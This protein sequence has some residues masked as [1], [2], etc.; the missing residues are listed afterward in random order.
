MGVMT[1]SYALKLEEQET[2]INLSRTQEE[3]I[4]YTSDRTKYTKLDRL[5]QELPETYRCIWEDS[6]IAA[7]GKPIGK[8]Y[9]CPSRLIRFGRPIA[10]TEEQIEAMRIRG[11]A[12]AQRFI[13]NVSRRRG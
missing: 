8:K 6:V 10:R 12:N 4:I 9:S 3:A 2:T 11:K 5:C 13:D 7:D 1:I